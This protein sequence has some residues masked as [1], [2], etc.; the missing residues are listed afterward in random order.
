MDAFVN[1]K[2]QKG[3]KP[4]NSVSTSGVV[5]D[6]VLVYNFLNKYGAK[7]FM[8]SNNE[9]TSKMEVVLSPFEKEVWTS[10]YIGQSEGRCV[11]TNFFEEMDLFGKIILGVQRSAQ[12]KPNAKVQN[13]EKEEC[14]QFQARSAPQGPTNRYDKDIKIRQTSC[15]KPSNIRIGESSRSYVAFL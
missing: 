8:N 5:I 13:P 4:M 12:S 6:L 2:R 11:L 1:V 7:L 14:I 3:K 10:I 15:T 9:W